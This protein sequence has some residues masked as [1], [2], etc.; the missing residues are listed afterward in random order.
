[1][2][3]QL[4]ACMNRKYLSPLLNVVFYTSMLFQF[5]FSLFRGLNPADC[6]VNFLKIMKSV[7]SYGMHQYEVMVSI[8]YNILQL[9]RRQYQ[10]PFGRVLASI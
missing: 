3:F 10:T 2:H 5:E 7:E 4:S 8:I 1:M 9:N 6:E